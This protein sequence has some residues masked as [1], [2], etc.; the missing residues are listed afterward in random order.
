MSL[1]AVENT[2]GIAVVSMV[3]L[4]GG[5]LLVGALW[6]LM[7]YRPSREE[8]RAL[9][10]RASSP[11]PAGLSESQQRSGRATTAATDAQGLQRP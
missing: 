1:V 3:I 6:Y 8:R 2:V 5:Y 11:S 9:A 10:E 7:V 4:G